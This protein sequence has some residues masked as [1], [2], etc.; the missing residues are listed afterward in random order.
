MFTDTLFFILRALEDSWRSSDMIALATML[1]HRGLHP[2]CRSFVRV[3]HSAFS[4]LRF[5]ELRLDSCLQGEYRRHT[6]V[7]ELSIVS[8]DKVFTCGLFAGERK[9]HGPQTDLR[10][11]LEQRQRS[12][13]HRYILTSPGVG[14]VN[15]IHV[16]VGQPIVSE[17]SGRKSHAKN[18]WLP[19]FSVDLHVTTVTVLPGASDGLPSDGG[20][21]FGTNYDFRS[22]TVIFVGATRSLRS[23]KARL[24]ASEEAAVQLQGWFNGVAC[25]DL[26]EWCWQVD[27]GRVENDVCG[28]RQT[29]SLLASLP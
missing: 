12:N 29:T 15:D 20:G 13:G 17:S 3:R 21:Y 26:G 1:R 11:W 19:R 4:V 8:L 5:A 28:W 7:Y 10:C 23:T 9:A 14:D 6:S 16:R 2:C 18:S 27:V 24:K 22:Q 25:D